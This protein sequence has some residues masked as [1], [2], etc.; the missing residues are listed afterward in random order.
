MT[1]AVVVLG[2]ATPSL[3]SYYKAENDGVLPVGIKTQGAK[4]APCLCV[5]S[6]TCARS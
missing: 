5:R 2:S 1:D 6:S 4:S 3:E